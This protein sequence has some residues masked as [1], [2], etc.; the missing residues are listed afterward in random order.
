MDN[1]LSLVGPL[2][3]QKDLAQAFRDLR[4]AQNLTQ[5]TL[6]RRSGVSEGSLKRFEHT[7]EISLASLLKLAD[8]L[9]ILS[10]FKEVIKE[11]RPPMKA[12]EVRSLA[13]KRKK[14]V[15]GSK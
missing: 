14:R 13:A 2:D 12:E 4:L 1:I 15:R 5:E 8:I 10:A 6:S 9:G 7:G 11:A 3:T